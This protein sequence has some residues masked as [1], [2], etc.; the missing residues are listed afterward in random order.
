MQEDNEEG[1]TFLRTSSLIFKS[2]NEKYLLNFIGSY[3][4]DFESKMEILMSQ[5]YNIFSPKLS[6][7]KI[8][9]TKSELKTLKFRETT[10]EKLTIEDCTFTQKTLPYLLYFV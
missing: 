6:G 1:Q 3:Y 10:I 9:E 7:N 5:N 4:Q 2:I 8:E